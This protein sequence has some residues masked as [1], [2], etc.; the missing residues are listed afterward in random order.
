MIKEDRNTGQSEI[1]K[2]AVQKK[3][4]SSKKKKEEKKVYKKYLDKW[5][6]NSQVML[7]LGISESTLA[8]YR[9]LEKIPYKKFFGKYIYPKEFID[10]KLE[11]E[12]EK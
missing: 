12:I 11:T 3:S 4:K 10:K 5:Y 7:I 8:R 2:D 1:K 6:D 9:K